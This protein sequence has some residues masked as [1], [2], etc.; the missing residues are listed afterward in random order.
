M[1][2]TIENKVWNYTTDWG[3]LAKKLIFEKKIKLVNI[4]ASRH[5]SERSAFTFEFENQEQCDEI[6]KTS[7]EEIKA[8][9]AKKRTYAEKK[10]ESEDNADTAE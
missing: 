10:K 7:K 3:Y 8:A 9:K 5:N 4:S 1:A 2:E 6:I